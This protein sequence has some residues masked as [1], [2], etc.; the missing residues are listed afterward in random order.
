MPQKKAFYIP[1]L[2]STI[3]N[4]SAAGLN[5]Q[6]TTTLWASGGIGRRAGLR[7]QY[8]RCEGSSP[9]SPTTI[10]SMREVTFSKRLNETVSP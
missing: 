1:Q 10:S 4:T 7:N 9:F 2:A 3:E 8:L 5:A 6:K